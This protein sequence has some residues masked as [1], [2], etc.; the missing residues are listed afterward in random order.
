MLAQNR[1]AV[2]KISCLAMLGNQLNSWMVKMKEGSIMV[3]M[4]SVHHGSFF[5]SLGSCCPPTHYMVQ[6]YF[7]CS[8]ASHNMA[9]AHTAL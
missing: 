4:A 1:T 6:L 7:E 3:H 2:I 9:I 5:W 8:S